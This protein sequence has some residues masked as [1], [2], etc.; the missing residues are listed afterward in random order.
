MELLCSLQALLSYCSF[1]WWV[2]KL[3]LGWNSTSTTE[4][5][6][7]KMYTKLPLVQK[8]PNLSNY[9]NIASI[10][11]DWLQINVTK[12]ERYLPLTGN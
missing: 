3:S 11:G 5:N 12:T 1:G 8:L 10:M 7:S 4:I 9:D 6:F 2:R